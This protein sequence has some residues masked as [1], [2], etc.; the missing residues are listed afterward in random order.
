MQEVPM[1]IATAVSQKHNHPPN[2]PISSELLNER[3]G[4]VASRTFNRVAPLFLS[5]TPAIMDELR[6]AHAA[7]DSE[8][9]WRI[10][11]KLHGNSGSICAKR[12]E[13]LSM[14]LQNFGREK[15]WAQIDILLPALE[16]ECQRVLDYLEN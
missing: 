7:R 11:H 14:L 2:S 4:E 16:F 5:T 10:A 6:Q 8:A 3:Y 9:F 13:D 15:N 1:H 12:L